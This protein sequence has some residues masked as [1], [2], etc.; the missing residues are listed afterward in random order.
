MDKIL[1][2]E[3]QS[4][5]IL[6]IVGVVFS[7]F[8]G[9][10]TVSQVMLGKPAGNH[11]A[12]DW[13]LIALFAGSVLSIVF[14]NKQKLILEITEKEI[15]VSYGLLT[16]DTKITVD[17][18]RSMQVRKYDALKE[19]MGWGVRYNDSESC[20][21]VSGNDALEI[22]LKSGTKFLIGTQKPKEITGVIAMLPSF[23]SM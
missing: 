16:S 10:F 20:F 2:K 4:N 15:S 11:P 7:V 17:D 6:I 19:F 1:F 22:E 12:P 14:F 5:K 13:L 21:T 9:V 8:F 23:S 18:I 3:A